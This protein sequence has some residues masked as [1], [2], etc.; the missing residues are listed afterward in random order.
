MNIPNIEGVEFPVDLRLWHTLGYEI[1]FQ[2]SHV[3]FNQFSE[4]DSRALYEIR[5]HS[6]VR[7]FMPSSDILPFESHLNWVASQLLNP[8][9]DSPLLLIGY[10]DSKPIGFGILKPTTDSRVLEAGVIV[11]EEW[12][13]NS[14]PIS[15]GAALLTIAAK[16]FGAD[17][18]VS[19]VNENHKQALRLNKGVGLIP[20]EISSKLGEI[21][22]QAPIS[23]LLSTSIY[24][25][26]AKGL[27]FFIHKRSNT[28]E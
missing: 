24:R 16:A 26:C 9:K 10:H 19:Y 4:N 22:F 15:V 23:I 1:G 21:F 17:T 6:S 11:I 14:L 12:Q 7:P 13:H 25:R 18:L 8:H 20:G 28:M 27:K 5:N 2:T 3:E